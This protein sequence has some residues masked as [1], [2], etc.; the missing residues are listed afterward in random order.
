[1]TNQAGVELQMRSRDDDSGDAST[2]KHLLKATT[3]RLQ[4]IRHLIKL[5]PEVLSVEFRIDDVSAGL[6]L[7]FDANIRMSA[8]L[9]TNVI[10]DRQ[11]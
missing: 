2:S 3:S 5:Q 9:A 1:M 10:V 6:Q 8:S 7:V 4:A 11:M